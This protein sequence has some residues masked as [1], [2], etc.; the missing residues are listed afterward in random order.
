[1][2]AINRRAWT[3]SVSLASR[4]KAD[5]VVDGLL[6]LLLAAEVR[7][8]SLHRHVPMMATTA[9]VAGCSMLAAA[10]SSGSELLRLHVL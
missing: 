10:V 7:L 9:M 5:P 2:V 6:Q 3:F 1:M 8:S 4:L